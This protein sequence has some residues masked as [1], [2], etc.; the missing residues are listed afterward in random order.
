M[1]TKNFT[2][3]STTTLTTGDYIVGYK[4]DG[5]TE[6]RTQVGEVVNLVQDSDN[7]TLDYN[8]GNLSIT[9]GN[10]VTLSSFNAVNA[11]TRLLSAG[12]D[13][14]DIF[15]TSE[16]DS[17]TLSFDENSK[18]LSIYS[19]NTVSLSTFATNTDFDSYKTDVA[20]ATPTHVPT[21]I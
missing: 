18:D 2:Q 6:I 19:G 16:T 11:Q 5:S 7:Q 12:T 14:F 9:S 21:T 10:S 20:S 8:N 1:A 4:Q 15:L 3:F 17:Q 13:L